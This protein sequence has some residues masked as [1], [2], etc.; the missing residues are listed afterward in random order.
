MIKENE[1]LLSGQNFARFFH[2]WK[3]GDGQNPLFNDK[4]I[5][6]IQ[7]FVKKQVNRWSFLHFHFFNGFMLLFASSNGDLSNETY[8]LRKEYC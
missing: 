8:F 4:F 6:Y 7:L 3:N 2:Q 1:T 5:I